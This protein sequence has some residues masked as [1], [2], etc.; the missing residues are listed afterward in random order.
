MRAAGLG[1]LLSR[2]RLAVAAA[3]LALAAGCVFANW[4]LAPLTVSSGTLERDLM[5]TVLKRFAAQEGPYLDDSLHV[6]RLEGDRIRDF[7]DE[8]ME[9]WRARGHAVR[10]VSAVEPTGLG[11]VRDR[12]TK[13]SAFVVMLKGHSWVGRNAVEV[14]L[15]LRSGFCA[16][17]LTVRL[18]HNLWGWRVAGG[19]PFYDF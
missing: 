7:S 11:E 5:H 14:D 15:V 10:P 18:A 2:R 13:R 17:G 8:D 3:A 16:N 4:L 12:E 6:S 1:K 9:F 19:R